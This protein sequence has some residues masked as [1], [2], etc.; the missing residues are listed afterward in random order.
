MSIVIRN[1][2]DAPTVDQGID[3][4]S[5][6]EDSPISLSV[7]DDAFNDVDAD[8]VLSYS[9][10]GL[11][12]NITMDSSGLFSGTPDNDDVGTHTVT[13]TA[14]DL[15]Q[16]TASTTFDLIVVNTNDAP[17]VANAI[18]D[19]FTNEDALFTLAV[20]TNTFNDVDGDSLSYSASGLPDWLSFNTDSNDP[21]TAGVFSG[22][23]ENQHVRSYSITLTADDGNN[24]TSST[25]FDI[26]VL[27]TNDAPT[28][29][30]PISNQTTDEDDLFTLNVPDNTFNDV[31]GDT[32]SYSTSELPEWLSFNTSTNVLSG[33]PTNDHVGSVSIRI[34]A[35]DPS[36]ASAYTTFVLTVRNTNDAPVAVADSTTVNEDTAI[37][38]NV[39]GN[40]YDVDSST[41]TVSAVSNAT[42]GTATIVSDSQVKFEPAQNFHGTASFDYTVADGNGGTD[43]AA[44]TISVASIND[45]PVAEDDTGSTRQGTPI[46]INVTANDSD[47][48][49][50]SL[51]VASVGNGSRGTTSLDPDNHQNV[52][53]SPNAGAVGSDSFTYSVSDGNGGTDQGTVNITI[54][55]LQ[56]SVPS[57]EP[58]PTP[59]PVP[60]T[61][62]PPEQTTPVETS[63]EEVAILVDIETTSSVET[64]DGTVKL[65]LP[66]ASR[67]TTYQVKISSADETCSGGQTPKGTAVKCARV[68][69]FDADAKPERDVRLNSAARL[70]MRVS[71]AEVEEAGGIAVLNRADVLGAIQLFKRDTPDDPWHPVA[72]DLEFVQGE[73]VI[74]VPL[75]RSFSEFALIIDDEI[76]AQA[77]IQAV[78]T[79]QPTPS[80]VPAQA[81]TPTPVPGEIPTPTPV[82]ADTPPTGDSSAPTGVLLALL[83]AASL[84]LFTGYRFVT[85]RN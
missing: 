22:T 74:T 60:L 23:P 69:L 79:T 80:P 27:N 25:T 26:N 71:A 75:L 3:D 46:T 62:I 43:T 6:N 18:S 67:G 57:P 51:S 78:P 81:P 61:V 9:A 39:I 64:V 12:A 54:T 56:Q 14:T 55:P 53:Y 29:A 10:S 13:V 65:V 49:G 19:L 58:E 85:R 48:D 38:I 82:V 24:A 70:E 17:T 34:T 32:L 5:T 73:M 41:L 63:E 68:E 16:A 30:N 52:I 44:V 42:N 59:T 83:T 8:D 76:L 84:L 40:D 21:D 66:P 11:P 72:F 28:V 37:T 31:D 33:T 2:N 7:P 1:T 15:F 36:E 20:P 47:V 45:A 35:K 4:H 50:D 77:R